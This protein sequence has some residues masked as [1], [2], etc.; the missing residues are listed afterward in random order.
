MKNKFNISK[1]IL[2][3]NNEL[4][5]NDYSKKYSFGN[6]CFGIQIESK[7]EGDNI[8]KAHKNEEFIDILKSLKWYTFQTEPRIYQYLKTDFWKGFLK[9]N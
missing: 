3:E 4:G 1:I 9:N 8:L 2:N 5:I 7:Q 6:K